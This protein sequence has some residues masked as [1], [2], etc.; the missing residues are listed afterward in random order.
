MRRVPSERSRCGIIPL[1]KL[2]AQ[3]GTLLLH[4][5]APNDVARSIFDIDLDRLKK[6]GINGLIIDLDNTLLA[7]DRDEVPER[8]VAWVEE[9]KAKGFVLCIASN[10]L[11]ERV[12]QI[13]KLLDVP[14]IPKAVKPR[15]KPFRQA[16]QI[17]RLPASQVAVVG[18][19]VFT[20]VLGGNRMRLYTILI[21]P[22]SRKELRT[23][24]MVRRVERRVI[25]RLHRK[26]YLS[27]QAFR[28]RSRAVYASKSNPGK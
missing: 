28:L 19:Q 24:R 17:L 10:G 26:G 3:G 4:F 9:A 11:T 15:K 14:A 27:D 16:L 8:A 12:F 13:A 18:D 6:L 25:E 20:D 22:V 1:V 5:L 7:W 2:P 23:T 21:N